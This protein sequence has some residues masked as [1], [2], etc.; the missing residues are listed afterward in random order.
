MAETTLQHLAELV[1]GELIGDPSQKVSD[2]ATL[3]TATSSDISFADNPK[4]LDKVQSC[5]VG[6][7]V[8][9]LDFP[10]SN[11]PCIV[12]ENPRESF[13]KIVRFFRPPRERQRTGI[14]KSAVVSESAIIGEDVTIHPGAQ[15]GDDVILA[16]G[17]T[18]HSNV[19]IMAGCRID[20]DA[21]LFPN[22]VLYEN[23]IV[24]KRVILHSGAIIGAYGFGY[25]TVQ[26]RHVI[27]EQLGYVEIEDDVEIG[28]CTTIDRGTYGRTLIGEGTKIDNQVMI[29]HNC[30]IGK[31]NLICSQV[32][33]AGSSATGDY[34]VMAGQVG[35]PDHCRIGHRAIL[36]AKSGIMRDVPDDTTVLGIP[37]TP[38]RDQMTK[39]ASIQKLPEMRKQLRRLQRVV[40]E[41]TKSESVV[42]TDA[43]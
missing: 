3:D 11:K 9:S 29:A 43:A 4:L 14:S 31:H 13:S 25:D 19:C 26:G 27:S 39:L 17:C 18:V 21:T 16:R 15:I 24:G 7:V 37:A 40:D 6:A 41:L 36:G 33:I 28:A 1:N 20:E 8:V 10:N 23:S 5:S 2:A 12:V 30:Q 38:E 35:V 34:V 32:G 22:V 42:Q